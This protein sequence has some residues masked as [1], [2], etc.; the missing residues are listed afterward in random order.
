MTAELTDLADALADR[1]RVEGELGRGGMATVYL[2]E[3][4]KHHRNVAIKV[5][6]PA[7][8]ANLGSDRFLR[9]IRIAASLTHPHILPL[10]DSGDAA[11]TL[12]Y[13]MP[14]IDGESLRDRL[15]REKQLPLDDALRIAREVADALSYAHSRG[16]VHRDVKP[17]NILLESGHAVVADFGIA[18]AISAAGGSSLTG[19]GMAVGTPA[20]M[21]PEQAA[22]ESDVDGRSDLYSLAC[23][24]YEMLAGQPPFT[25]PTVESLVRQHIAVTPPS[26]TLLRPAVPAEVEAALVRALAKSPADRFN[27]VGQFAEALNRTGP[28]LKSASARPRR[29]WLA[30][31]IGTLIVLAVIGWFVARER[32]GGEAHGA[33]SIAV[34]P[35]ETL[36][37]GSDE[38]FV[39]GMHGQM[40]THLGKL[41]ELH[42]ASRKAAL[43]YRGSRKSEREIARELNV[44]HLLTASVQR[45][46]AQLLVNVALVDTR[47]GRELWAESYDRQLSAENLFA[48]Q[49]EI[50]REVAAALRVRL[51]DAQQAEI[52]RAPT[53]SLQALDLFHRAVQLWDS[54]G[55]P[56]TDTTMV[57]LLT[58]AVRADPE[59]APAWGML[60]SARAWLIRLGDEADTTLARQ[61][62]DKAHALAP[63]SLEARLAGAYYDYYAKADYRAALED[64]TAADR[65]LPNS[66]DILQAMALLERR[67][68]RWDEAL[69]LLRRVVA[70]DPRNLD[71]LH[72]LG[73]TA[74]HLRRFDEAEAAF[75]QALT[76]APSSAIDIRSRFR[77]QLF[78]RGDT[79]GARA[80]AESSLPVLSPANAALLKARLAMV[81]RDYQAATAAYY[82]RTSEHDFSSGT[83]H[84]YSLLAQAHALA[85]ERDAARSW[86]DS[87]LAAADVELRRWRRAGAIDPFGSRVGVE[88]EM[89]AAHAIKGDTTR[90]ISMAERAVADMPL[91]RDAVEAPY[92]MRFLMGVYL[93]AGRRD[94]AMD[95]IERLLSIPSDM[96][97]AELRLHPMYDPLRDHPRFQRLIAEPS[98]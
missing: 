12:Y 46:D 72:E 5:L 22:G 60:A 74:G 65:L 28:P 17:E 9:E 19:V 39:L 94:Q 49:G 75:D 67:L 95:L 3:D 61:A 42:V 93:L 1:Y 31:A 21:S 8:S 24:L 84:A 97:L 73:E 80:F 38:A 25:G 26:I 87:L 70:R 47:K 44:D 83:P 51:T 43:Q 79:A 66:S 18:R 13:V 90:A 63:G 45:S 62:L 7:L 33:P 23:V 57:R 35:F 64:L 34:L 76:V 68:G 71:A 20:Y 58:G 41:S 96:N 32:R 78:G 92:M 48:I 86:A 14:Y 56:E 89:A 40:V 16:V 82:Q 6:H 11:G 59:F 77:Q 55:L 27:P 36:G 37:A 98:R 4:L 2:A 52:A 50:A 81:R 88:L 53:T 30:G 15:T 54:R 10:H 85:G 69:A 29:D 91:S